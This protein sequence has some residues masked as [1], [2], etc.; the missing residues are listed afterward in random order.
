MPV[1]PAL[2]RRL[3]F[4][5]VPVALLLTAAVGLAQPPDF[6][7]GSGF[8][9]A[10]DFPPEP[11]FPPP[12]AFPDPPAFPTLPPPVAAPFGGGQDV[13]RCSKCSHEM[14]SP[15]V[16][17][18]PKCGTTFT[19]VDNSDGTRT[20]TTAGRRTVTGYVKAAIGGVVL[21]IAV[22]GFLIRLGVK[23]AGGSSG[24]SSKPKKRTKP[25]RPPPE[26]FDDEDDD[27][28]PRRSVRARVADDADDRP[29]PK[30]ARAVP[31]D[32]DAGYEVVD[33]PPPQ[34]ARRAT[35]PTSAPVPPRPS[36]AS[37]S[38][39]EVVDDAP[40]R[41]RPRPPRDS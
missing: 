15:N 36:T 35:R 39:F 7:R 23:V 32:G 37:D 1:S 28:P 13:W 41:A 27:A 9:R 26:Y 38:P 5:A 31:D 10:P 14:S 21:A 16:T 17:K 33:A 34:L 18:C 25:R 40:R 2:G 24:K 29:A 20:R 11:D 6:P 30:R 4:A 19:Y 12:P 3:G 22:V 8:P